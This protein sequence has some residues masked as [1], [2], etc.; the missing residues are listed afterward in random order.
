MHTK[1]RAIPELL[2]PAGSWE[3]L[4]AAVAA[5]ADAVYLGGTHFSARQYAANFD[6]ATLEEAVVYAHARGV[7]VYVTVNTLLHDAELPAAARYLLFLYEIGVDAVLVQDV[8]LLRLARTIVPDLAL[9]ASTQMTVT[10]EA[11]VRWA[12]SH[13]IERVVLARELPLAE[14]EGMRDA[15]EETGVGLEVFLH[16]ALCYAYS[17]QCLLS[18]V[19]GG[20]SGNRGA[21]AQP[22]RKPYTLVR[23]DPDLYGRPI[24]FR[25]VRLPDAY[26]LSTRDI[27]LYPALEEIVRAPIA[28]LKI[29]GRMK[30]PA[31]VATVVSIYRRALD[32]LAAGQPLPDP[33]AAERDLALAFTRGF[34]G[35]YL[36]G[37]RHRGVIGPER[38]DNRGVTLG[39]VTA[40]SDRRMEATVALT[41]GDLLPENGDGLAVR[42]PGGEFGLVVRGT[43]RVRDGRTLR[44]RF[45]QPAPAGAEV[46]VTRRAALEAQATEIVRSGR[47]SVRIDAAVTWEEDGTPVV[48]GICTPPHGEHVTFNV[49]ADAPMG[50]ARTRPLDADGISDHLTRTGGTQFFI[51][52]L[53]LQYPGGLFA[54]ASYLNALRRQVLAAVG[55][56]LVAAARPPVD[57]IAAARERLAALLPDLERSATP[58]PAVRPALAVLTDI[59]TGVAA[60]S[61]AGADLI[62]FEPAPPTCR[63]ETFEEAI[64]SAGDRPLVW[65]WPRIVT[66][67]FLDTAPSLLSAAHA[68]G[69]AGVMVEGHGCAEAVR[70]AVPGMPLYGGS[71]LNIWN[72]VSVAAHPDFALLTLSPE[73]SGEEILTLVSRLLVGSP[74]PSLLVQGTVEAAVTEDCP[75]ATALGCPAGC[76][77]MAWAL[78]DERGMVFPLRPAGACRTAIGNAVETCLLDYLPELAGAGVATFIIDARWRGPAYAGEMTGLYREALAGPERRA[79][80]ERLKKEIKKHALGGI[81]ASSYVHGTR[82]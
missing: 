66:R 51:G 55:S 18:S 11:G 26:R 14:V 6:D 19:I 68:A 38:P 32:A 25:P 79:D 45:P 75:P 67:T 1:P 62:F 3:A 57:N 39:T 53:D 21:C 81:T 27:C 74:A 80:L 34:T 22:C 2:A 78:K 37:E 43:P 52:R 60:A 54:P 73:L 28:S 65:K 15:V 24:G 59:L 8:G 35:G 20:R 40:F 61:D 69:I 44:L 46:A 42:W 71:G 70:R 17:G 10:S 9:H 13:G 16:G 50:L 72:H 64:R 76:S 58:T 82:A 4:L 31:Y 56:A 47:Q 49:R 7:R 23:G 41:T 30:T 12:A 63:P 77:G 33:A 36:C 5:G 48:A 29:E